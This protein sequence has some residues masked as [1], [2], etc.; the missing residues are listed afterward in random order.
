M[1]LLDDL[2]LDIGDDDEFFSEACI[3]QIWCATIVTEKVYDKQA[4]DTI[5]FVN[6]TLGGPTIINLDVA[7]VGQI[8]VIKDFK[9]DANVNPILIRPPGAT[10][11]DGF[12]EFQITQRHQ[13]FMFTFDG[14]GWNA[15]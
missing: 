4:G 2:R 12:N 14:S 15:I 9:G 1:G 6:P 7:V 13:S 3:P 10:T 11:I 5:I 8:C